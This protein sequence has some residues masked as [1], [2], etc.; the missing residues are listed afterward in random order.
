MPADAADERP[1]IHDS[2]QEYAR[3][4]LGGLLFSLPILFTREVWF[5]AFL[6]TPVRL[7]AAV[8]VTFGLLIAFNRVAGL[9]EN[10]TWT[11]AVVDSV[12]EF[13]LGLLISA[14][15]FWATGRFGPGVGADEAIGLVIIGSLATSLGVSIGTAQLG[16]NPEREEVG[17]GFG[18]QIVVALCGA[19]IVAANIAPTQEVL[20][21]SVEASPMALG[22]LLVV[23]LVLLWLATSFAEV[24]NSSLSKNPPFARALFAPVA[25]YGVAMASAGIYLWFFGI[26]DGNGFGINV[27]QALV[28]SAPASIGASVGRALIAS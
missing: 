11:E 14:L 17:S 9:R 18:G 7:I 13:G 21:M 20:I 8:I 12:E 27:R 4:V 23:T 28:L 2:A 15:L 1:S 16:E 24:R 19:T 6:A 22:G 10:A 26:F 3:G 25:V 5:T